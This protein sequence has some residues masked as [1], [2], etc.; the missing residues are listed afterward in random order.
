MDYA[1]LDPKNNKINAKSFV[2]HFSLCRCRN[3]C[4][5]GKIETNEMGRACGA[6]GGG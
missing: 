5:D 6:C 2:I 4:A 3:N 1:V